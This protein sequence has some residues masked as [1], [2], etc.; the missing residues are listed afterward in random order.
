[1]GRILGEQIRSSNFG[2]KTLSSYYLP[3]VEDVRELSGTPEVRVGV[4]DL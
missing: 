4:I 2:M 1:M 3:G